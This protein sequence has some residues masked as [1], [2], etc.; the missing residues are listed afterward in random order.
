MA[1]RFENLYAE[2]SV[3]KQQLD[4][5]NTGLERARAGLNMARAAREE[6]MVHMSYLDLK[7]PISGL[8]SRRMVEEGDMAN[9]GH[10]LMVIEQ[11]DR[12][13]II[14]RLSERDV[15]SISAGDLVAV[16][17]PSLD[18]A[19]FNVEVARVISSANPGS[20]T[21]DVEAYVDNKIGLRSGMFARMDLAVGSRQGVMVPQAAIIKRGQLK[22]IFTVDQDNL[23]HLVW[24]RLGDVSGTDVEVISGLQGDE[25]IVVGS[26]KPLVEGD[27]VVR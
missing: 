18:N 22:G 15:N 16:T 2:K 17:V 3:S 26:A 25:T 13:K 1:E 20:R 12:M 5:V 4:D 19:T 24:V 9:P 14:A 11:V 23:T 7:A 8:V 6:V 10:P 21:Y 27:R